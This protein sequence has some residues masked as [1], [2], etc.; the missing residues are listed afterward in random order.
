MLFA[1]PSLLG[2]RVSENFKGVPHRASQ[3][4]KGL[5]RVIGHCPTPKTREE[6]F[7]KRF[8]VVTFIYFIVIG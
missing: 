5:G 2:S 6:S 8:V 3:L 7:L 1:R 4:E